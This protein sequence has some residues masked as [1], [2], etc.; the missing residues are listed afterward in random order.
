[1]GHRPDLIPDTWWYLRL[2]LHFYL[3]IPCRRSSE[4]PTGY[5][6]VLLTQLT[7]LAPSSR[8]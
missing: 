1:M 4:V 8:T 7:A 3:L 6:G 5:T 2:Y